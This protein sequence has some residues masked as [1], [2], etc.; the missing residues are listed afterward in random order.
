[1]IPSPG[2][3]RL[4]KYQCTSQGKRKKVHAHHRDGG[5]FPGLDSEKEAGLIVHTGN[6]GKECTSTTE[7]QNNT[8]LPARGKHSPLIQLAGKMFQC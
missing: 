7:V 1:M 6:L 3:I 8:T 2:D 4:S 5:H